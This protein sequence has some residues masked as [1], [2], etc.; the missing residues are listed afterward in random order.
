MFLSVLVISLMPQIYKIYFQ[1]TK[2]LAIYFGKMSIF[3]D[4]CGKKEFFLL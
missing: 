1:S 3:V 4:I 2:V